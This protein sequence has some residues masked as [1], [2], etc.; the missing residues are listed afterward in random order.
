MFEIEM[1]AEAHRQQLMNE[2]QQS[3]LAQGSLK[4]T[5]SLYAHI[6]RAVENAVYLWHTHLHKDIV[7]TIETCRTV[8]VPEVEC[9]ECAAP[10]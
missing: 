4:P 5:S 9:V 1:Q 3:R 2:A 6:K 8:V 7:R 10:A